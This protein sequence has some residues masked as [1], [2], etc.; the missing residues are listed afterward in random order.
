MCSSPGSVSLGVI[1]QAAPR[2]AF[3]SVGFW[4]YDDHLV[5]IETPTAGLEITQPRGVQM[6][7]RMFNQLHSLAIYG[8]AAR[9]LIQ[10]AAD[11]DQSR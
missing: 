1:P 5:G 11:T 9:A 3:A 6:Y 10:A 7:G 2:R 8:Q 4:I